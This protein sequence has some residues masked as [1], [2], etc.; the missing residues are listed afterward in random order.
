MAVVCKTGPAKMLDLNK[1][2]RDVSFHMTGGNRI[3]QGM[4]S[5]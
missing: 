5:P 2:L 1:G 4:L 3:A